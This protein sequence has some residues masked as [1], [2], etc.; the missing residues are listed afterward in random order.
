MR[1]RN[2]EI[3]R[4]TLEILEAGEYLFAG[5]NVSLK[6][7][8][9]EMEQ[10]LVYLPEDVR[11]IGPKA[12]PDQLSGTGKCTC[13]CENTDSF[14]LA[15]KRSAEFQSEESAGN[16]KPVL[17]LN[18]ANPV[19]PGGGVRRG[20]KA[21]EEDLCR[22]SSLLLSLESGQAAPY[23]RYNR[24]LH[25]YMGSHAIMIHPQV[26]ILKD[27]N[28][29]LLTETEIVS[30]MTC[31]APMLRNGLEGLSQEQYECLMLERITGMLKVASHHGYRHLILGAFG[32]GAFQNDARV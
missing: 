30:V 8:R 27:D 23:Y 9:R 20:A 32:C 6:L 17:V 11:R 21:Q 28:G 25:T 18:L 10:A 16:P 22:K 13:R 3:L 26:E 1:E 2:I 4:D 19:H 12:N 15:R 7:S 5:K 24:L 29:E 31:A 14:T